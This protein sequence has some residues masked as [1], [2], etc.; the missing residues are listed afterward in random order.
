MAYSNEDLK[1][2]YDLL[3]SFESLND[4]T[5][6]EAIKRIGSLIDVS[7]DLSR[8]NGLDKAVL[9]SEELVKRGL[10]DVELSTLYYF[11]GNA[12]AGLRKLSTKNS[13]WEWEK[14]E[15]ENEIIN[16][17]KALNSKGFLKLY[18]ERKCE[19]LTNLA[20]SMSHIGRFVEAIEYRDKALEIDPSF[21]MAHGSR[22]TGLFYYSN[23]LYDQDVKILFFKY[24]YSDLKLALSSDLHETA[25]I[26]FEEHLQKIESI[27]S[28]DVLEECVEM[29]KFSLG[30]TKDEIQYRRWCLE[31]RLFLNPLN[32]LGAYPIAACDVL[33]LPPITV[34]IKEGPYYEGYFNQLKQEFASA[35]FL[36][37]EGILL[38]G[39]HFSDRYVSL[40]DTF[41]YPA[42]SLSIERVKAAFRISYSLF[43]K[44]GY[45]LN[46]YLGLQIHENGVS[47]KKLWYAKREDKNLRKKIKQ[48][49][50]WP[51]R[52]LF[53]L[54]K[55]LFEDSPGFRESIEPNAQGLYEIRN[56]LE[57]KYLKLH[58][59][60]LFESSFLNSLGLVDTLA[61]SIYRSDFEEKTLYLIK[62]VRAALI[63]LPLAIY[64]E[65][66]NHRKVGINGFV[67]DGELQIFED[68]R[69]I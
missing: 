45:F 35:R 25:R 56:H 31:N 11:L 21:A 19:I 14:K 47:F 54:S 65:E 33:S 12:W 46:D 3:A 55:D 38:R 59:K 13:D 6:E 15:L 51:L 64:S 36:Y 41:D 16:Y 37:Y 66:A 60:R 61:Y 44:I 52:G 1:Q 9:L 2:I 28:L 43:D 5:K 40:F 24:A 58:N 42:Y 62:M 22:G 67:L 39:L 32:D 30:D 10:N 53:W 48:R 68:E 27:L 8:K 63:Y 34:A 17:R 7:F 29:N 49:K 20:N 26:F 23:L 50:N 18:R 69:K 57:H 4:F